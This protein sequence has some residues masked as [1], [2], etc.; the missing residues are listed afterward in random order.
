MNITIDARE[1]D[2]YAMCSLL[3]TTNIPLISSQLTLGDSTIGETVIIERKT[4]TD[5]AA[6]I[7]DGRYREQSFRLQKAL[8]ENNC[9]IIYMIEGNLDL[10]VGNISKET[11]VK[12]MYSLSNKGFQVFLTKNVK[13][14]AYFIMQFAEKI[15][16]TPK[17]ESGIY[18]ETSGIIQKQKNT[19]ITRDNISIFMLCQI[20][21][22]STVTATIIMDNY[23]HISLLIKELSENPDC[24]ETFE[25]INPKTNKTKKLNKNVIQNIKHYL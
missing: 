14:T 20:P 24:L 5:L 7:K 6:S 23:K 10:Y 25:Y 16:V 11:L 13:E 21:G 12:T 18:E 4:L 19:N 8:E 3:N 9:K 2:L 15:K 1:K 22:I 17:V